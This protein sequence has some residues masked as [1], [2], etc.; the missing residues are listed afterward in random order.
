[1]AR[2]LSEELRGLRDTLHSHAGLGDA[3][4]PAACRSYALLLGRLVGRALQ[5]E[6]RAIEADEMEAVALDLDIAAA[7]GASPPLQ[8]ALKVQQAEIQR[9]LDGG[10]PDH[11]SRPGL[12]ALVANNF[13]HVTGASVGNVVTFPRAPRP[14]G[15]DGGGDAA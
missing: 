9:E 10:G 11:V 14:A 13:A 5:L 2:L 6:A 8:A 12:A 4:Q 7:A 15:I 3:A 1:M